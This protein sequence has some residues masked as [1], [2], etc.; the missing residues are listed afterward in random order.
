MIPALQM[1]IW[2]DLKRVYN[3]KTKFKNQN[4]HLESV[5]LALEHCSLFL[6][7]FFFFFLTHTNKK[8]NSTGLNT[9]IISTLGIYART[10]TLRLGKAF[11]LFP[12]FWFAHCNL[13]LW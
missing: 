1:K 6:G 8:N 4:L 5:S 13:T 7:L 10:I 9:N 12:G 11:G 2:S 3:L